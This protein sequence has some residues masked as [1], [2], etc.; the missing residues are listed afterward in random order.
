MSS[1]HGE[2]I[3]VSVD[4][5]GLHVVFS[6]SSRRVADFVQFVSSFPAERPRSP[7]P[8]VGSF[9]LLSEVPEP[10]TVPSRVGLG[11][12]TRDQ[13]LDSFPACPPRFLAL[14]NKLSGASLSGRDQ[15][16]VLGLLDFGQRQWWIPASILPTERRPWTLG[17][18]TT[19]WFVLTVFLVL[20][21][22]GLP[23]P[24]G[25]PLALSRDLLQCPST[26]QARLKPRS[27]ASCWI[28]RRFDLLL[29]LILGLM[30]LDL[31][32]DDNL[33]FQGLVT[34]EEDLKPYVL[35]WPSVPDADGLSE[36]I[37]VLL[38]RQGG[39][40]LG[41]P[42]G[43]VPETVLSRANQG[44][45]AGPIGASTSVVVPGML[46]DGGVR[47]LNVS[48]TQDTSCTC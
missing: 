27:I 19:L 20:W 38:K 47:T 23:R 42:P 7:A 26:F 17:R 36:A 31:T 37:V 43:F 15:P 25:L 48:S 28:R 22:S 13:I 41:L 21:S 40:L 33:S 5:P 32:A 9:E 1:S 14:G 11:L 29:A 10:S 44:Q 39:F 46:V 3:E 18:S 4:L 6:G 45:D 30:A 12:E 24:T 8:S 34:I 35:E 2:G 16:L